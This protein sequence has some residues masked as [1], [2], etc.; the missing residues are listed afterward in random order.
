MAH[1]RRKEMDVMQVAYIGH[2]LGGDVAGNINK[3][4]Q[5]LR[6]LIDTQPDIAFC[7]NWLAYCDVLDDDNADHRN[8][9]LRDALA[10]ADRCDGIVLC[11]SHVSPGMELE[12]I[13]MRARSG[14]VVNLT[15]HAGH[16]IYPPDDQAAHEAERERIA[17]KF[18]AVTRESSLASELSG[19]PGRPY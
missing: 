10:L 17:L 15:G 14:W 12:L 4:R 8:R 3:A 9:G 13:R 6:Y 16:G 11:G 5:W 18:R 19:V 2:P 1:L 7:I